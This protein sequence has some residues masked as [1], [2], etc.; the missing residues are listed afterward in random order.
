MSVQQQQTQPSLSPIH[1]IGCLVGVTGKSQAPSRLR[2]PKQNAFRNRSAK[3]SRWS[4]NRCRI[5]R[6]RCSCG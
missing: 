4:R 1:N 6:S 5:Q 2:R 3:A